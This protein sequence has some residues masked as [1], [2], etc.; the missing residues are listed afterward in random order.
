MSY[1]TGQLR[2]MQATVEHYDSGDTI[3]IS[4]ST[5][6]AGIIDGQPYV[7]PMWDCSVTTLK[8]V[9]SYFADLYGVAYRADD[10]RDC[11]EWKTIKLVGKH[12][13]YLRCYNHNKEITNA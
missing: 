9:K 11:I 7:T 10:I 3:L 4:Y 13:L 2:R 6:V 5:V 12:E 1:H 8:H